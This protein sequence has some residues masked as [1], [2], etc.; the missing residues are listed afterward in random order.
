MRKALI[1][2]CLIAFAN[3]KIQ[4]QIKNKNTHEIVKP[5]FGNT[6]DSLKAKGAVLIYDV[7]NKTYYSNDFSWAKKGIIPA[8]TFKIPNSIIALETGVIKNDS[9][10]FK[11]DG[12]KRRFKK[13]EQDLTFKEAFR[14]SCVPCYQEV[15]RK[16][17]VNRMKTYLKKLN[18]PGMVFDTLTID[19]FWLQGKSKISQIQQIDFLERFYFS[20]LPISKRTENIM[21]DII[22]IEKTE[23]YTLSGKTGWGMRNKIDNGWLVGYLE[24][25]N[26]V[27]FFATNVEKKNAT[28][29][30]FPIIRLNSTKEAF[31]KLKLIK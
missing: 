30:E 31:R 26:S 23:S 7:K 3:G 16:I 13:W 6:I 14:A 19:N 12:E 5:E 11:W 21:K 29:D 20:K 2:L 22:I 17:G 27:Y 4:A 1:L 24:T 28:M 18:Y 8:S 25:N 15:A 9:A 10:V